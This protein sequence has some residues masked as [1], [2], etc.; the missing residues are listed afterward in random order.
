MH[1]EEILKKLEVFI[2]KVSKFQLDSLEN[3]TFKIEEKKTAVDMV[4]E[5]D[6]KSEDMIIGFI[7]KNYPEHSILS[8]ETGFYEGNEYEWVIDPIDGTTNYI[9]GYPFHCISIGLKHNGETI[10][11]LVVAPQLNVKFYAIKGEGSFKNGKKL[12]VSDESIM[13]KCVIVTGFPYERAT[14]NP[15]VIPFNNVVNKVAGIRRSGSAAL[16][17]CYVASGNLDAYWEYNIKEWDACAGEL[18][19]KEAGGTSQRIIQGKHTLF[20]FGNGK[21]DKELLNI[22]NGK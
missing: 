21:I 19:L 15:N 12:K 7:N 18:I 17:L 10:L 20:L 14:E 3:K 2:D 11:G 16:D 5:I 9:H 4:T 13:N 8:E 22:I 1:Y 6:K